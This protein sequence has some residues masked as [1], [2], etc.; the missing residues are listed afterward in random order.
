M[1][2]LIRYKFLA[3]VKWLSFLIWFGDTWMWN[4]FNSTRAIVKTAVVVIEAA[5]LFVRY[6]FQGYSVERALRGVVTHL[7]Q[8]NQ[9]QREK[10]EASLAELKN[11]LKTT[12]ENENEKP[13]D[14]PGNH[15]VVREGNL[16]DR[17][18]PDLHTKV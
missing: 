11:L 12:M 8:I 9:E 14:P 7:K 18:S 1:S 15:P 16:D 6:L 2:I 4:V 3:Q 13:T 5:F 17:S 10:N